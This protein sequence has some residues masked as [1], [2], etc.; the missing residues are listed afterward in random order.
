MKINTLK[1]KISDIFNRFGYEVHKKSAIKVNK[2]KNKLILE[3]DYI[4]CTQ[5]RPIG[6]INTFLRDIKDRGFESSYILDIGS[7]KTEWSRMAKK[8]FTNAD[9]YLIDPLIEM[10]GYMEDFCNE[11]S[12][13]KYIIAGA[14]SKN[15]R[16][17]LTTYGEFMEGSTFMLK[18]IPSYRRDNRQREVEVDT[19]DSLIKKHD[20]KIPDLVKIDVQGFEFEALKGAECLF[21]KSELFIIEVSLFKFNEKTPDIVEIIKFMLEK[22]YVIY[23]IAGFLRRPYDGALGQL[24]ICFVKKDSF[25][26][27]TNQ[28]AKN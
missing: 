9:F 4:P 3:F 7:N 20:L 21:G 25:L 19:I 16:L 1:N 2:E 10:K 8:I 17:I 12:G 27:N 14:G 11:F 5:N 18:E 23:D 22:N 26:R 6:E 13:S 24:D 15:D 28:W